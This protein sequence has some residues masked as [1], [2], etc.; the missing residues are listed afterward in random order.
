MK[1]TFMK[2]N[3]SKGKDKTISIIHC[4]EFTIHYNLQVNITVQKFIKNLFQDKY[5]H[6]ENT[7]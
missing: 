1:N 4:P 3:I 6:L 5:M 2:S 7:H